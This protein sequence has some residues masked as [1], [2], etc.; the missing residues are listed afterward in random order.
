MNMDK[1]QRAQRRR[2]TVSYV[3]IYKDRIPDSSVSLLIIML[4]GDIKRS[5]KR[6]RDGLGHVT[7]KHCC[8]WTE[9][10]PTTLL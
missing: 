5:G 3:V 1:D 2:Q 9:I 8:G 7:V 10:D 6:K 4:D